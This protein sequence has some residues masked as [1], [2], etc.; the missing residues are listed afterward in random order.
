MSDVELNGRRIAE[1]LKDEI[2]QTAMQVLK[3]QTYKAF[4]GATNDD[5]RRLA[6]AKALV[7]DG[8][9]VAL[10]SVADAGERASIERERR[11]HAPATRPTEW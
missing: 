6:Q 10:Q 9:A 7:L 11:E 4:L 1:F 5:E 2:V 8:F 3:E